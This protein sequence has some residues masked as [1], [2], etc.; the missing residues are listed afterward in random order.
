MANPPTK[1]ILI[2][3]PTS[4]GK[5]ALA[6]ALAERLGGVVINADSMQVYRELDV[7]TARPS[8]ADAA[9]AQH[10]LYGHVPAAEAYS[11][12]RF[13]RE[14]ETEIATARAAG[15]VPIVVGGTGLYFKALTDGLSPMPEVPDDVRE[16]WRHVAQRTE[17][18]ALHAELAK[19]DP[20]MASRLA[21]GDQQRVTRALEV[22]EAS[23]RSLADWQRQPGRP[24]VGDADAVKFVLLPDREELRCRCDQR[25]D[26]M[27]ARGA[28]DEVR[29]MFSLGLT[30]ELP[31]MRA[32]GVAP[33]AALV[34]GEM[35]RDE[36]VAKAKADTR[37][38]AKRQ[39][40]WLNRYMIAWKSINSQD[41]ECQAAE[42]IAFIQR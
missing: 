41:T 27:M 21:P 26:S 11:A 18:I 14:A 25:F 12:G 31:A 16:H 37:K 2:A 1:T 23:G 5:S 35:T 29:A 28:L 20:E 13:V 17:A 32:L 33:L 7:L 4:S 42:L 19:R 3:G 24:V 15:L 9:R 38:F 8:A 6:L 10:R 34:R 36:A 39:A 40:T 22:L 30:W